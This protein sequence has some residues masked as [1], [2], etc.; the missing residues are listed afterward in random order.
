[1]TENQIERRVEKMVD[2]LDRQYLST[3]MTADSY[4]QRM[5][6]I[7]QWAWMQNHARR[8]QAGTWA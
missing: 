8:L 7:D 5:K 4:A 3:S 6:Q 2:E 1:M